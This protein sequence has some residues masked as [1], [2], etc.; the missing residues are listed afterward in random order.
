MT[1]AR[2]STVTAMLSDRG[3]VEVGL[4]FVSNTTAASV[5]C[6]LCLSKT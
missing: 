1:S 4:E 3:C 2:G 6:S 5:T